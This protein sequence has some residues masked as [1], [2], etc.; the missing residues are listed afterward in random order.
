MS[1]GDEFLERNEIGRQYDRDWRRM[2]GRGVEVNW[3]VFKAGKFYAELLSQCL[4][5]QQEGP[6]HCWRGVTRDSNRKRG[7]CSS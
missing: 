7:Q 3:G 5:G 1:N 2:A 6:Q 4:P